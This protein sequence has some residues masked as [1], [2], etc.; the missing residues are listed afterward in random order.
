[1][2]TRM[3][4]VYEICAGECIIAGLLSAAW[5][6]TNHRDM[7]LW[8]TCIAI[9]V[10]VIGFFAYW[11]DALWEA[12]AAELRRGTAAQAIAD[13]TDE[14]PFGKEK[15]AEPNLADYAFTRPNVH[16]KGA[17]LNDLKVG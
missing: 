10:A 16:Y 13:N 12:D 15:L 7:A 1:M 8:G 5:F 17:T 4:F 11:Q 3:D 9:V 14:L 6:S 2:R